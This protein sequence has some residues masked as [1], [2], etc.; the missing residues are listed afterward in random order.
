[1]DRARRSSLSFPKVLTDSKAIRDK[2]HF[3]PRCL[4][5]VN[6]LSPSDCQEPFNISNLEANRLNAHL[7]NSKTILTVN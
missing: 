7:K 2:E 6:H 4:R 3:E 1:M 5:P